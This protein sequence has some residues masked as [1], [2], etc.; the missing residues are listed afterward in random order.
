MIS[1]ILLQRKAVDVVDKSPQAAD[2]HFFGALPAELV[3]VTVSEQIHRITF[4]E[5]IL[6]IVIEFLRHGIYAPD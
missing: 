3:T 6:L 2:F 5:V 1:I 4:A